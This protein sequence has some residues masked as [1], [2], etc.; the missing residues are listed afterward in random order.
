MHQPR[1]LN[2]KKALKMS[3][4]T[5]AETR[6]DLEIEQVLVER[7]REREVSRE[8][9]LTT[10]WVF[11][12]AGNPNCT[13]WASKKWKDRGMERE[14]QGNRK[15]RDPLDIH[16]QAQSAHSRARYKCDA[17]STGLVISHHST[18]RHMTSYHD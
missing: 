14:R 17:R 3:G 6:E 16:I 5:F 4:L 15:R 8:Y 2:Y 7:E 11:W 12:V 1:F 13:L 10:A 18:S 9:A